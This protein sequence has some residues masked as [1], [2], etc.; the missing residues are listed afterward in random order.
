LEEVPMASDQATERV[1]DVWEAMSP[2]WE[3]QRDFLLE[4]TREIA[5]WMLRE[6]D[7]KPGETILELAAG[8]GDLGFEAARSLGGEG[9]LITTDLAPGMVGIAKRR[10]SSTSRTPRCAWPTRPTR[11]STETASTGS[12][13][14]GATC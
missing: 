1:R 13:A 14:A 6:L 4:F 2:G 9:R 5:D 11:G 10:A 3:R 7:P 8:T 12:S